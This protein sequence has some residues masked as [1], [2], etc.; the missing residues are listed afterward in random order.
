MAYA[1]FLAG[2]R[3]PHPSNNELL[4]NASERISSQR[5]PNSRK[6]QHP[7]RQAPNRTQ[8]KAVENAQPKILIRQSQANQNEQEEP[9]NGPLGQKISYPLA[10]RHIVPF[11]VGCSVRETTFPA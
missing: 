9:P 8:Q 10:L 11:D 7:R 5:D 6:F 2:C 3:V 1:S 4:L